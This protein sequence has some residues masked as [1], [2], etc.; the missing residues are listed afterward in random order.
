MA[1]HMQDEADLEAIKRWWDEN[2][3]SLV[4]AVIVAVLGM[5][6]T[7]TMTAATKL[8]PFSSHQRLIASRSASSC[9]WSATCYSC[10]RRPAQA[11]CVSA[12]KSA[13]NAINSAS[14][15]VRC[16]ASPRR[17]FNVT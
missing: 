14:A 7:A 12:S 16:A 10:L 4:A 2:G 3:K 9:I 5:P 15:M 13:R 8:L 1:D 17:G 11:P 6:R